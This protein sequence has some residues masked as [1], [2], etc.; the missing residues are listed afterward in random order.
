MKRQASR[1]VAVTVGSMLLVALGSAATMHA[2]LATV[3]VGKVQLAW[4]SIGIAE[5]AFVEALSHASQRVL[6]GTRVTD[7]PHVRRLVADAYVRLL[8]MKLYSARCSDD[9]GG[10]IM[11]NTPWNRN[12]NLPANP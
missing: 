9:A 10:A 11:K 7:F 2:A 5:H 8:A 1:L 4:A 6:Y 3:N 12:D